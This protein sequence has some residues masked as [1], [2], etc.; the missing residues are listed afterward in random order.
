[1]SKAACYTVRVSSTGTASGRNDTVLEERRT[2][3]P[4][5]HRESLLEASFVLAP[6]MEEVPT[7]SL[8]IYWNAE[9]DV[10]RS[11]H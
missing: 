2:Q 7:G 1:M 4:L 10:A 3:S 8:Y 9:E 6:E 5:S 11:S